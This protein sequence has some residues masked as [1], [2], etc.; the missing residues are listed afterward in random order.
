MASA[1]VGSINHVFGELFKLMA[2]VNIVHVLYR[3]EAPA[4]AEMLGGQVQM[5]F[6]TNAWDD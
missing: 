1:G 6:G 5:I 3:G 4:L 2:G